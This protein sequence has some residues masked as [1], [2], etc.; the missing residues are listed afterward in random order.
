[1]QASSPSGTPRIRAAGGPPERVPE[2]GEH[3]VGI[4]NT[5]SATATEPQRRRE[6]GSQTRDA[7]ERTG[8][9]RSITPQGSGAPPG[10]G[11]RRPAGTVSDRLY[12]AI[13]CSP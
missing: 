3:A 13:P 5:D 4:L 7:S 1:M 11:Q 12:G 10:K 9:G 6:S 2:S 8:G